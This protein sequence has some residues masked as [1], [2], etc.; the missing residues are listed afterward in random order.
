MKTA[1]SYKIILLLTAFVLSVVAA[2]S[3]LSVNNTVKA[4]DDDVPTKY[5]TF[6][7]IDTATA[8]FTDGSLVFKPASEK[9]AEFPLG[10]NNI[11][12]SP[13]NLRLTAL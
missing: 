2:F 6:T 4:S 12:L 9:L 1:K 8:S 5:F 7:N 10:P 3:F 11:I 13:L